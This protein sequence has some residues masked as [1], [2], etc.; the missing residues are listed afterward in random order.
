MTKNGIG[1][2]T[3][4][5]LTVSL[6]S[7]AS[8][9]VI[10]GYVSDVTSGEPLPAA[11]VVVKDTDRGTSTN[12]DGYF[13]I[14]FVD[15][16][17]HTLHVTYL[18][19]QGLDIEVI[20]NIA[21]ME[22]LQIEIQPG[23]LDLAEVE[24]S[25]E[26][27]DTRVERLS[28]TV[29]TVPVEAKLIRMMPSLGA[30][31]D[32]LRALQNIPGVKASSDLSSAL[33]VRGGSPDQTLIMMDHNVV[34]NPTHLFGIFS[35]FNADAIKHVE[36]K[37]GGFPAEY[38]G[39]SGSVL[40]VI[41]KEGNRKKHEGLFS[42]GLIS[43]RAS[44]EGPLPDKRGSYAASLRR[45]YMDPVLKIMR[46][47][48]DIDLPN[49]YFYD[50]NGKINLDL[51]DRTTLSIAGY[52]GDDQLNMDF[53]PDDTRLHMYLSWG[54]RTLTGRF[55]HALGRNM[56]LSFGGAV[57]RYRSKWSFSNEDVLI[58]K[59]RNRLDDYSL[60]SDLEI[61][62]CNHK[63][64]TGFWLSQ[65]D[66]FF[67]EEAEDLV[68]VEVDEKVNNYALYIQDKWRVSPLVEIMPGLRGYYH[69]EGDHLALDPRFAAVYHW[70]PQ[71]RFK[72]AG[73]RYTQFINIATFG[74]GFSNFDLWI[75]ID[76]SMKPSYTNQAVVGVE[77][78]GNHALEYTVEGYYTDM[79]NIAAL[80]P[81]VDQG[82][83]A[84]DAFVQGDGEA[85]GVELM[86]RR[87][88][89]RLNGWV[90]YSLSWSRRRFENSLINNG[91]WYYP[92]WDR[93]HDFI[94]VVNYKLSNSWDVSGSWRYNTG[95]GFTAGKGIHTRR[96]ARFSPE[97]RGNYGRTILPGSKNNYRFPAD[98]RLDLTLSYNHLLL[99]LQA[100]LNISIFNVY[101]RRSYWIRSYDLT[102]NPVEVSDIKLLP[103]L[104]LISY[105]VRV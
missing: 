19:Y 36:L 92:K 73:G 44:L 100:K 97:D 21:V 41:T 20:V 50:A 57:S 48:Q 46:E 67:R 51:T 25:H 11:T 103:V 24:V 40:E 35:A 96:W 62:C 80:D 72:L 99:K 1:I 63:I 23:A 91:N 90:G 83:D 58:D 98:H 12:L 14:D 69:E 95:Q 84:S 49:Y 32:V 30:E 78:D 9:A 94:A 75:P 7:T 34:Y 52:W 54:N 22:P 82:E 76:E 68:Y 61:F 79:H 27:E 89:G 38:G 105:E 29:S 28:P 104:P 60:K 66:I 74:E 15:P 85:Y 102:M 81:M 47:T 18:G 31:M 17:V 88:A 65:Y 45:T 8:S 37:K 3:L 16:G 86:L 53:G 55:R 70:D 87:K 13:A 71:L 77:Y 42:L 64:K 101:N 10:R 26:M 56:F 93:R 6:V 2:F 43:A 39:R 33:Y 4:L 5:F 59:A